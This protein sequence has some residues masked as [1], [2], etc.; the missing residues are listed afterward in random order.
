[1]KK[2][3]P[4]HVLQ[5]IVQHFVSLKKVFPP[6]LYIKIFETRTLKDMYH[7]KDKIVV[8]NKDAKNN[9]RGRSHIFH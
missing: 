3:P 2:N 9:G 8:Q 7:E 4:T 1:M 6:K 5:N